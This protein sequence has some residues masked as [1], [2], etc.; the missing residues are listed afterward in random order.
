MALSLAA[1]GDLFDWVHCGDSMS[2]DFAASVMQGLLAALRHIHLQGIFHRDVKAENVL[3][4]NSRPQLCDFGVAT[5]L[6]EVRK[7]PVHCGPAGG[8]APEILLNMEPTTQSDIFSAGCV[9]L[10]LKGEGEGRLENFGG[11]DCN[12]DPG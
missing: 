10:G 4:S 11:H 8:T 5:R 12:E 2:E 1:Q 6:S 3:L 7:R 9:W